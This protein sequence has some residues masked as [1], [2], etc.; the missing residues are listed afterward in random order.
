LGETRLRG[1]YVSA[2]CGL[3]LLLEGVKDED[4]ISQASRV[5]HMESAGVI[6]HSDFF[7][8]F[9]NRWHRL[10]VVGLLATGF[11]CA[12]GR[13]SLHQSGVTQGTT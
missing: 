2:G 1:V 5:D 9:A 6:P 3:R 13:S 10:E 12:T 4:R 11:A 8:A 7:D